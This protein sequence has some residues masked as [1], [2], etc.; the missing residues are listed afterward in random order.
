[1]PKQLIKG[2]EAVVRGAILAGCRAFY[3]YPITPASEIS[4]AAALL[5]AAG[6]RHI[7]ASGKRNRRRKHALRRVFSRSPLHDFARAAP[8]SASCRKGSAIWRAPSCP[9]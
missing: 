1:M 8:A 9:A 6:R 2:N 7:S 4:E 5:Y 3:A